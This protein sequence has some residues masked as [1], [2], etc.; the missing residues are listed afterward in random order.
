MGPSGQL[1]LDTWEGLSGRVLNA[2]AA[3]WRE[4]QHFSHVAGITPSKAQYASAE[5]EAWPW[6]L[7]SP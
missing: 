3:P 1:V 4:D 5:S 2:E 7:S 6:E